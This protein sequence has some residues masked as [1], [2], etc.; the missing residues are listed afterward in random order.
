MIKKE[1]FFKDK[2]KANIFYQCW[3]PKTDTRAILLVSHGLAEHSGRYM[4]IV[5][6]FV[7]LGFAVYALDHIGHGKSDG[8]RGYVEHFGDYTSTLKI[9]LDKVMHWQKDKPIFLVG[10]SMG[11]LISAEFLITYKTILSGVVFSA[12]SIKAPKKTSLALVIVGKVLSKLLP[13]I[14]LIKLTSSSVSSD[15]EVVSNY[16]EDQL[17]YSGRTTARLAYEIYLSIKVIVNSLHNINLPVLIL[18]GG[19]DKLVN[20]EGAKLLFDGVGSS[21]KLLKTYD[22]MYHE[23]FNEPDHDRVLNDLH[24]WL[25]CHVTEK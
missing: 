1:G 9:Y 6:K 19:Q 13:K 22:A 4:N 18:Q 12:P 24:A 10:H 7:P 17:V 16:F 2:N 5:N 8:I 25:E 23:V 15:Q 20:P 14:R 3:L 11:G 21:D